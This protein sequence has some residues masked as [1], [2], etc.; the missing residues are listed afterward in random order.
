MCALSPYP[1]AALGPLWR[2]PGLSTR[3]GRPD[4]AHA[5]LGSEPSD[6][7][8]PARRSQPVKKYLRRPMGAVAPLSA[9]HPTTLLISFVLSAFPVRKARHY[10]QTLQ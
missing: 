1:Y 5:F 2:G 4:R 7:G 9:C 10:A 8:H 6:D 3:A